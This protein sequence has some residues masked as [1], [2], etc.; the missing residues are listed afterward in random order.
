VSGCTAAAASSRSKNVKRRQP[1]MPCAC[2]AA[3]CWEVKAQTLL[4]RLHHCLLACCNALSDR[5][6]HGKL[7]EVWQRSH[8]YM[9]LKC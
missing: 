4:D 8:R 3:A 5:S 6:E 9:L 2:I 7:S 1:C